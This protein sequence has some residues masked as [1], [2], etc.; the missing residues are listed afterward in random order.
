[1]ETGMQGEKAI[2][3]AKKSKTV[4]CEQGVVSKVKADSERLRTRKS[5][6]TAFILYP[7]MARLT[8]GSRRAAPCAVSRAP[9]PWMEAPGGGCP[10]C[11]WAW[12]SPIR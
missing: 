7:A 8:K 3:K 10:F 9:W 2:Y 1:M 11:P 12:P 5:G 6:D 4:K